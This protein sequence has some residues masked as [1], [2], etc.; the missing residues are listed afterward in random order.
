MI[1]AIAF[2]CF[3]GWWAF[4]L[5]GLVSWLLECYSKKGEGR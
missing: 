4:L 5:L 2:M 3:V 1:S